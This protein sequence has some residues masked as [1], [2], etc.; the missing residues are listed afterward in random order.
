M[1][2]VD[3]AGNES[4]KSSQVCA[5]TLDI[6][7]PSQPTGLTVT[8]P[9]G[10]QM[11]IS[12][13]VPIDNVGVSSYKVYRD[14]IFLKTVTTTASSDDGLTDGTLYCYQVSALDGSKNESIK[15]VQVCAMTIDTTAPTQP[16]NLIS[17]ATTSTQVNLSW[18]ESTDNVAVTA[19]KIYRDNVYIKSVSTVTAS[20]NN[21]E[22]I[23]THCYEITAVDAADN[24]SLKSEQSCEMTLDVAAP[25]QPTN[26][27]SITLSA[28]KIN[29]VWTA[30]TDDVGVTG[31]RIYS[32]GTLISSV[33]ATTTVIISG[34]TPS[35]NYCYT[36]SA[37]DAMLNESAQSM[38]TC[39]VTM[40]HYAENGNG[41]ILDNTTMLLWQQQDDGIRR[42]G[43]D[44]ASYC[45]DLT[46]GGISG[47][48]LPVSNEIASI[49][50]LDGTY[51]PN[52]ATIHNGY[53]FGP[54]TDED[55]YWAWGA[56]YFGQYQPFASANASV[57][58]YVLCVQ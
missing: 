21:L 29:V 37:I 46:L 16:K 15:S 27:T 10:T 23:T 43:F 11:N 39:S 54:I 31:Y 48:R 7:S 2:A 17:A 41:T 50:P 9:F 38:Q 33:S 5:T 56:Y 57:A 47:W 22:Y 51:F 25:S 24:E 12:W 1:T 19:Y 3:A 13:T 45:N 53:G 32:G 34:L 40:Q 18:S 14:G 6:T 35:T 42:N 28:A 8:A 44:A 30:S 55:T 49:A 52:V 4:A 58:Y 36:I 26:A 20:D